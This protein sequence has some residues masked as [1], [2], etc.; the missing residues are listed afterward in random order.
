[1][2]EN[3]KRG[4]RKEKPRQSQ[5]IRKAGVPASWHPQ[6]KRNK[7]QFGDFTPTSSM[8]AWATKTDVVR[9]AIEQRRIN[10]REYDNRK[11]TS[12]LVLAGAAVVAVA[13]SAVADDA[14]KARPGSG[15]TIKFLSGTGAEALLPPAVSKQDPMPVRPGFGYTIQFM[16]GTAAEALLPASKQGVMIVRPGFGYTIDFMTGPA[17]EALF[18]P[19]WAKQRALTKSPQ[20]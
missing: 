2:Q 9:P 10:M 13:S 16:T 14:M 8:S 7:S 3:Q 17:A 4:R 6:V 11:A 12:V 15:Y 20:S 18:P 19:G 1:M 5:V